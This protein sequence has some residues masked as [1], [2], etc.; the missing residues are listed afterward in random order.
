MIFYHCWML[1]SQSIAILES[2]TN[3]Q[4]YL[5]IELR[6][7]QLIICKFWW[8][9]KKREV[10]CN[11][12]VVPFWEITN[13]KAIELWWTKMMQ[14]VSETVSLHIKPFFLDIFSLKLWSNFQERNRIFKSDS[15]F[16]NLL[17]ILEFINFFSRTVHTC[18]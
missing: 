7:A 17:R 14:Y 16:Q 18:Y 13:L 5:C 12:H 3:G 2:V 9:G 15:S 4:K 6:Y 1:P 11:L 10:L 8:G